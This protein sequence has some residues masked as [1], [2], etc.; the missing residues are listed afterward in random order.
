VPNACR[1]KIVGRL[2]SQFQ[3]ER[4]SHQLVTASNYTEWAQAAQ[5]LDVPLGR[6]YWRRSPASPLYDYELIDSRVTLIRAMRR[7]GNVYGLMNVLRSGLLRNL[8]NIT[9][10]KLF[11]ISFA[12]TKCLIEDYIS[13]Y[14]AAI[15]D[16]ASLPPPASPDGT[17]SPAE[18]VPAEWEDGEISGGAGAADDP[19]GLAQLSTPETRQIRGGLANATI[20]TQHKLDFIRDTRQGF[21]RSA[22]VLQGGAIFGMCHLGVVK[23]L[24]EQGLLPRIIVGTATGAMMAALVGVHPEEDLLPILTGEGIDLSAFAGRTGEAH[25]RSKGGFK[26]SMQTRWATLA[27]RVRRFRKEGYFLDVKVLEECVRA[28]VGDLTFEEAFNRSRRILN[29]TVVTD[30]NEGIPTLLNYVTTPNVVRPLFF[31]FSFHQTVL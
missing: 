7:E 17:Q 3:P 11:N 18:L 1:Q 10:P 16:I 25:S 26:Q 29:I 8:G 4:W 20:P 5:H 9:A 24:H 22:L 14:I 15:V 12:G 23:A 19:G 2:E 30:D 31:P 27:R 6:D 21:G 28:N 13:E